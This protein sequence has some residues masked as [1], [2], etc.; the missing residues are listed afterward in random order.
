MQTQMSAKNAEP[1]LDGS[2]ER[3]ALFN[4][5]LLSSCLNHGHLCSTIAGFVGISFAAPVHQTI[6]SSGEYSYAHAINAT[7]NAGEQPN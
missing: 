1:N 4:I 3:C 2:Q 6:A 7:P 5:F